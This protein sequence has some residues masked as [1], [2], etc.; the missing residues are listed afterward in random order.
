MP[1]F[2]LAV[3]RGADAIEFDIQ[4]TADGIPVV[5][6][7][8]TLERTTDRQGAVAAHTWSELSR[9]DAGAQFSPDGGRSFP[10]RNRGAGIP[11]LAEVLDTFALPLL[12][13]IKSPSTQDAVRRVLLEHGAVD[14]CVIASADANALTAFRDPPFLLGASRTDIT[15]LLLHTYF[16]IPIGKVHYRALSVPER[17]RRLPI[18]TKGFVAAARR[19]GCPVHVWTVDEPKTARALWKRGV[20]GIVT[21]VPGTMRDI[22]DAR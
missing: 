6:H 5:M 11:T 9:A 17:H 19:V 14:R 15:R 4:M 18:P 2:E 10:W 3:D 7:D 8:P 21:N 12:I 20:A 1:A 16:R 22:R 13:E